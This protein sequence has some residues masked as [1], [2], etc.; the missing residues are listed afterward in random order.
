VAIPQLGGG[1]VKLH[2][3]TEEICWEWEPQHGF[4]L[5]RRVLA[6]QPDVT[7]LL[8]LNDRLAFGAYQPLA[9]AGGLP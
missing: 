2:F 4:E 8:C 7:A 6:Q 3:V 9:G 5:T 1:L